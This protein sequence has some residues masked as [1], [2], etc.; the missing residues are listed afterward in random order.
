MNASCCIWPS[1][2]MWLAM[3]SQG[4]W[5]SMPQTSNRFRSNLR[6]VDT[7]VWTSWRMSSCLIGLNREFAKVGVGG[8]PNQGPNLPPRQN[9]LPPNSKLETKQ[10][11]RP[12]RN[13]PTAFKHSQIWEI[14]KATSVCSL[15]HICSGNYFSTAYTVRGCKETSHGLWG[16]NKSS[17]RKWIQRLCSNNCCS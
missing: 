13:K 17:A 3:S 1:V 16:T 9:T 2:R 15:L 4:P 10:H 12:A 6:W 14:W 11:K 8:A 7:F 5:S